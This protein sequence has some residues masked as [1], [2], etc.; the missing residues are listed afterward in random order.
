MFARLLP[1][2]TLVRLKQNW[3]APSLMVVTLLGIVTLVRLMH[4]QKAVLPIFVTLSGIMTLVK[5]LQ[6]RNVSFGMLV[7]LFGML[8]LARLLLLNASCPR[9]L[10]PSGI[11]RVTRP[12]QVANPKSQILLTLLGMV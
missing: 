1:I 10:T 7:I 6:E 3:N 9:L 4:L 8:T 11:A 2:V 5:L 12:V